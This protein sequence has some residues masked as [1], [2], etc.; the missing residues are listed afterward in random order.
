MIRKDIEVT[1]PIK[2]PASGKTLGLFLKADSLKGA[3][4]GNMVKNLRASINSS[5]S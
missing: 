4:R 2:R 3:L 1:I 5:I